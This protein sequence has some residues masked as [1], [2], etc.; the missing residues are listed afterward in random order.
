VKLGEICSYAVY[1]VDC[2]K[3]G[4]KGRILARIGGGDGRGHLSFAMIDGRD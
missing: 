2:R 1:R 3:E 4:R